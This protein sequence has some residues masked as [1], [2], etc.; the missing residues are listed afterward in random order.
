M[1]RTPLTAAASLGPTE[2]ASASDPQPKGLP[3]ERVRNPPG[4]PPSAVPEKE[5]ESADP[6]GDGHSDAELAERLSERRKRGQR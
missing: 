1:N 4:S 2:P 6:V 3:Q 5:D